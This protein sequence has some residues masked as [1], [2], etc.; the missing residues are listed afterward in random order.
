MRHVFVIR[1]SAGVSFVRPKSMEQA[2]R[3]VKVREARGEVIHHV[4][5]SASCWCDGEGI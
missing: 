1:S 2:A 3:A 5:C 4:G